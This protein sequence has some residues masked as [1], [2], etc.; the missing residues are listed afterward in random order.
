VVC[1]PTAEATQASFG[2][3]LE[4]GVLKQASSIA[5]AFLPARAIDFDPAALLGSVGHD[6]FFET[7]LTCVLGDE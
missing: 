3:R 5:I 7:H 2:Q 4:L 6:P 1:D